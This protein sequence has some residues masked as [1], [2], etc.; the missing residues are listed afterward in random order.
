MAYLRPLPLLAIA[1]TVAACGATGSPSAAPSPQPP[2]L[3]MAEATAQR[4]FGLIAGGDWGSAWDMWTAHAQSL[5]TRADVVRL[6]ITC[7]V[8][9]GVAYLIDAREL[10]APDAATVTW[11]RGTQTGTTTLRLV[12]GAWR[13]EPDAELRA[14]LALGADAALARRRAAH[15]SPCP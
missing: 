15:P 9:L 5:I 2:V 1:G 13:V 6:N 4:Q 10:T 14:E 11:H 12:D 7:P 3:V 8:R